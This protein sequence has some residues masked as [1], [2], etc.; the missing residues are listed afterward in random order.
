MKKIAITGAA[1]GVGS[2]L[3][4]E[5]LQRG[6]A[7]HLIDIRA[8]D[9]LDAN[10]TSAVVDIG[11]QPALAA[12]LVG[13]DAVLHL[14]ACTSDAPWP[15]QMRLSLQGTINLFDAARDAGVMRVV[16]ASSNHVVGLHPRGPDTPI[17]AML[18]PDSRYGVGKAFGELVGSLYAYKY[19]MQVLAVRIGNANSHP[20]DRR[21][22]GNWISWR[23]L[24][25]LVGIGVEHPELVFEVV[26]GVS[27]ATGRNYDNARARALGYL[28]QDTSEP[29]EAEVL[30]RDPAPASGS[31][32]AALPGE[33]ALGG[34]FAAAEY[35][36]GTARLMR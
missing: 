17:D 27:D 13:C 33:F 10:E 34:D 23:D 20:I 6:Y 4:R 29:W 36:G 9:A 1:G 26:W 2:G 30:A 7:L 22:L 19:G 14:A 18:R 5:L 16:Y 28:A 3:R 25:Q 35:M 31:A 12:S 11:D 8:I 24:A 21:R 15:D 32:A